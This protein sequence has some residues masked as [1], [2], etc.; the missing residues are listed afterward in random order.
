VEVA[1]DVVFDYE[2][3]LSMARRLWALADALDTLMGDREEAATVA[4][5]DWKGPHGES[6][7]T[8]IGVERTNVDTVCA[9]FRGAAD[10]WAWQW[11]Q[12]MDEQN[13]INQAR[14]YEYNKDHQGW[15]GHLDGVER[16]HD[17]E[18]AAV[19]Q[20]PDYHATRGFENYF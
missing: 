2:G 11:K 17:P 16:P 14:R 7:A 4:L 13:R 18:P 6:F 1:G 12:A 8:R 10:A 9:E 15:F 20:A 5:T 19:P 3:A